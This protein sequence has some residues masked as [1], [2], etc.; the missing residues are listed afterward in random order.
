MSDVHGIPASWYPDPADPR[1]QRY[2]DGSSWTQHVRGSAA[3]P[4][5]AAPGSGSQGIVA[6]AVNAPLTDFTGYDRIGQ[7]ASYVPF[8]RGSSAASSRQAHRET[9]SASTVAIWLYAFVP[10]LLLVHQYVSWEYSADEFSNLLVHAALALGTVVLA[11]LL[12][13]IDR[14][15]LKKR[16]FERTPPAILGV[17]PPVHVFVRLFT[18]SPVAVFVTLV[19][20]VVQ[21]AVVAVLVIT[22]VQPDE[23]SVAPTEE[24][25]VTAGMTEPF[26]E[27]QLGYLLTPAG[28]AQKIRFDAAQSELRYETVQCDPLPSTE[29]GTQTTC[30]ATGKTADYELLVQ[31]L[32]DGDNTPF[33]V[34]SV[35]PVLN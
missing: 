19:A 29:L 13:A 20:L 12:A 7:N 17:V 23:V 24:P 25:I 34:V 31:V 33:A 4:P 14:S 8:S 1:L 30:R 22:V 6:S 3:A 32:P 35:T 21:A 15:Q 18:T 26:T 2:W 27:D 9:G 11:I 5:P 16:G 28:M 10:L